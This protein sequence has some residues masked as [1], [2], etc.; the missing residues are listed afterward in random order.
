[1]A[2]DPL[3]F[4]ELRTIQ[5]NDASGMAR[6]PKPKQNQKQV[7]TA[8]SNEATGVVNPEVQNDDILPPYQKL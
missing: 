8:M 1:M 6:R 2:L 5:T 7:G 4:G 3:R